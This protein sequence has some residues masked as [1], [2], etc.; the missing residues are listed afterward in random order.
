[1]GKHD[2]PPAFMAEH[3][4][5]NGSECF[6]GCPAYDLAKAF[7]EAYVSQFMASGGTDFSGTT[8]EKLSEP[9]QKT[10]LRAAQK[11]LDEGKIMTPG[12][13][14][15]FMSRELAKAL[16]KIDAL[17]ELKNNAYHERNM[18]VAALSKVYP[19]HTVQ[20][21]ADDKDWEPDWRTI[22]CI[23]LPTGQATWHVHDSEVN[24]FDHLP[25]ID[26]PVPCE[27]WDGHT[28]EEKYERVRAL[29]SGTV[30]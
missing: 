20:H 29:R 15:E 2:K 30:A 25:F 19:A 11:L 13:G 10:A 6:P 3:V 9:A 23:H 8:W 28:T 18:L 5:G 14:S 1:M 16:V 22:V 17:A 24:L 12:R 7:Y 27:G 26:G 21:S 4:H